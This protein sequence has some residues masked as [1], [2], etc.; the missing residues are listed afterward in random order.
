LAQNVFLTVKIGGK[1]YSPISYC[2]VSQRIDWHHSFEIILP[3][4]GFANANSTIL[5]QAKDFIGEKIEI[6]VKIK[7]PVESNIQNEF[8]GIITEIS[9][10]RRNRGNKEILIRGHSLTILLDGM[11]NCRSYTNKTL[12]E[13][14]SEIQGKISQNDLTINCTPVF[15]DEIPYIVQYKESNYQFLNRIADKYGEWCYYD[16][17]ELNFGRFKKSGKV[18]LPIDKNLSDFDFSLKIENLNYKSFTY[19]YLKNRT[20]SQENKSFQVNDLDPYG[21]HALTQSENVFK[22][23]NTFYS[24]GYFKDEKDFKDQTEIRKAE[25]TK[26][27]IVANGVSDNPYINVGTVINI[28]GES[29]NEEDFG[30]FIIISIN[31]SIDVTANY[32]NHFTAIPAQAKVPPLNGNITFPVSEIQ[33][34][35]VKDNND[36]DKLGRVKV[37][38]FWQQNNNET[39]W[40]RVIQPY[41]GKLGGGEQHG[42]YFIPE[43]GDEVMIGFENDNPD[44]P[45]VIGN[46]YHKNSKP[47][48]WHHAK[49][50]T[51]SIR[52]KSGNQIIF[53]DDNG[54]EEIRILNKDDGSPTNEISLSMNN[55]GKITI[56]TEGELDISADIIKI[57][58][59]SKLTIDSGDQLSIEGPNTTLKATTQLG[60]DGAQSDITAQKLNIDGGAQ[61]ELKGAIVKI[62]GAAQVEIKAGTIMLN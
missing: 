19:D 54:K 22:Q 62:T 52:T 56:K 53:N 35:V 17:K 31:H 26:D 46:V 57:S 59:K 43:I 2:S 55:K 15:T 38:L 61:T 49:N 33:P 11:P 18:D 47:D 21:D 13:L 16:G 42:F 41:G 24:P 40:I 3:V 60:I 7:K 28:T 32:V 25:K 37:Q 44:K 5:D 9:L 36:P 20:Y 30:E 48:H 27:L 6:A 1:T 4:D 39:P 23:E 29:K 58:A 10:N 12:K 51:K 14:V 45:F 34:A 50:N 8:Y